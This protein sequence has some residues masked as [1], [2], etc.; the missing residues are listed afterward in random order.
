MALALGLGLAVQQQAQIQRLRDECDNLRRQVQQADSQGDEIGRLNNRIQALEVELAADRSEL[1]RL[2]AQASKLRQLEQDYSRLTLE[3]QRLTMQS[4]VPAQSGI[5]L[6]Q[7]QTM[8]QS[9]TSNVPLPPGVTDLGQV[10]LQ[11]G[12]PMR[13]DLGNGRECLV[14][15]TLLTDGKLEMVFKSESRGPD[16]LPTFVEQTANML[17]Q[18]QAFTVINGVE[19]ALT[20]VLKAR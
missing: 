1:L 18:L 6:N 20:P 19:V 13:L 16:G 10:T 2:R 12:T 7:V 4:G 15:A 5:P 17:P 14:T 8:F 3:L 11:D 9:V